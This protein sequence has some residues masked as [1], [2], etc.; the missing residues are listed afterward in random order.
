M[1]LEGIVCPICRGPATLLS[2]GKLAA[3]RRINSTCAAGLY[4][5]TWQA[6]EL[7]ARPELV[8]ADNRGAIEEWLN[9]QRSGD[10]DNPPRLTRDDIR[11]ITGQPLL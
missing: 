6:D 1:E 10:V 9:S 11:R 4:D 3:A 5:I 7:L 2:T 8:S